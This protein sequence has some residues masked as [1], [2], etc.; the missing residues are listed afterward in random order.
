MNKKYFLVFVNAKTHKSKN[1]WFNFKKHFN[2]INTPPYTPHY[3]LIEMFFGFIKK[4]IRKKVYCSEDLLIRD[5][6]KKIYEFNE[7]KYLK[8]FEIKIFRNFYQYLT[9]GII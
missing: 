5:I 1:Y 8:K 9:K 4:Q 3:N 7:E 6:Q 2:I